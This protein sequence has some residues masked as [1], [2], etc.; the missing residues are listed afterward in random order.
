MNSLTTHDVPP[1]QAPNRLL[2]ALPI[3]DPDLV[4]RLRRRLDQVEQRLLDV[5]HGDGTHPAAEATGHLISAGG[6][7]LR[8]LLALLGAEFGDPSASGVV[9]AAVITELVHVASLHH[10]DVMDSAPTRHGVPSVNAQWGNTLAVLTGDLLLARIARLAAEL[11]EGAV[12]LY[13]DTADRL[14]RGQLRE[15]SSPPGPEGQPEHHFSVIADKSGSLISASI[16]LGALQAGAPPEAE[17]A[18]AAFGEHLGSAFQISDDLL[19][20]T[21]ERTQS[22]KQPGTDLAMGVPTLPVILAL[23]DT[24]TAATSAAATELRDLLEYADL[25]EEPARARALALLRT[26]PA[27]DQTR[28]VLADHLRRAHACLTPLPPVPARQALTTL[29][30]ALV[31][32]TS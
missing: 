2:D 6:K 1:T 27:L 18:L 29:C 32:R 28:A 20:I 16:R 21:S 5:T 24:S 7:R 15:L 12:R 10:D 17:R 25:S 3:T 14:V 4:A 19:D 31:G 30:D 22:G 13:A 11:G 8:P 26:S 23:A 9:D